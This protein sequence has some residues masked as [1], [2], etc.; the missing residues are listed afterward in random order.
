MHW[1]TQHGNK[2]CTC[3]L[4]LKI[5]NKK[6]LKYFR[7]TFTVF[8]DPLN[9]GR[10]IV[11]LEVVSIVSFA[12][13]QPEICSIVAI[14]CL[15]R[16]VSQPVASTVKTTISW[17][18]VVAFTDRFSDTSSTCARTA[19]PTNRQ[20]LIRFIEQLSTLPLPF[21]PL[22]V[23]SHPPSATLLNTF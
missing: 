13:L 23:Y 16:L 12:L 6:T 7:H 3:L 4:Q 5:E 11:H 20:Y 15:T 8:W 1:S 9:Q 21:S 10:K 17:V 14:L 2:A 22:A 19:T 18:W